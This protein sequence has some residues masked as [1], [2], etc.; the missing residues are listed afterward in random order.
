M[1]QEWAAAKDATCIECAEA[2]C[3]GLLG[4]SRACDATCIECAEAKMPFYP[5]S[6]VPD[7]DAT[8]IECAEAKVLIDD[9]HIVL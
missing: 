6:S 7:D 4:Y 2:K 5:A 1:A 3:L 8:C 9:P